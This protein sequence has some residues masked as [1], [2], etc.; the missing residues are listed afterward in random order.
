MTVNHAIHL[1]DRVKPVEIIQP[2]TSFSGKIFIN[3]KSQTLRNVRKDYASLVIWADGSK[4]ND[5]KCKAAVCWK[6]Q[7]RHTLWQT[8]SMF[9]GKN[10]KIFSKELWAI[11]EALGT[12]IRETLAIV[13]T[14]ITIFSDLQKAFMAIR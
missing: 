2:D 4:L 6:N 12:A 8:K 14:L 9:L 5:G 3:N 10:L 11:S 1:A 13:K 7:T